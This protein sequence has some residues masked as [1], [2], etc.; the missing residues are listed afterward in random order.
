MAERFV[1]PGVYTQERDFSFYVSSV[2][3]PALG[4]IGETPRG[5]AFVP[6]LV[7]SMG[8]FRE[9]FG[10]YDTEKFVPYAANGWFKHA[11]QAV[12]VRVLG[13]D[14]VY[15]EGTDTVIYITATGTTDPSQ[16]YIVAALLWT[17]APTGLAV[18]TGGG[19]TDPFTIE[20]T[21]P[22]VSGD[23]RL[24]SPTA[25]DYIG[26]VFPASSDSLASNFMKL[27]DVTGG[28]E[29]DSGTWTIVSSHTQ[30]ITA[31][32]HPLAMNSYA[33]ARTPLIVSD[34]AA[35]GQAGVG[36]FT[37]Y[38]RADGVAANQQLKIAIEN[39][40]AASGDF[41]IVVREWDDLDNRQ[42]VLE[43][44]NKLSMTQSATTYIARA[45]GDSVDGETG[46][47]EPLSKY[48]WVEV[49][50]GDH[51]G[52]VP[53]G[54]RGVN[55][56]GDDG[57]LFRFPNFPMTLDYDPTISTSR[58]YLG[59][60][61]QA[62]SKD[63]VMFNE[64]SQWNL[65]ETDDAIV[66]SGF[67]IDS[68]ASSSAG[69]ITS[70]SGLTDWTKAEAKFLVPVL[71]GRDGWSRTM[72]PLDGLDP[73]WLTSNATVAEAF[74]DAIDE[75]SNPEEWNMN[76]LAMPG[77]AVNSTVGS[78]AIDMVESRADTL[79][80]GDMPKDL[81]SAAAAA[82]IADS[83]DTNYAATYWPYVQFFDTDNQQSVWY[84]PTPQALE[85]IAYT[86]SVAYPWWAAAGMNRGLLTD[87]VKAEYRLTQGER[88]ELYE[89]K[90]NP[91]ATF[92]GQGIVIWGQKTLQTRT[93][94]LDRINVRRML[95]YVRKVIAGASKFVLFEPN[96]QAT[97]DR[98]QAIIQPVLDLVRI[99]RGLEDF[100]IVIDESVNTPEVI[101]RGQIIAQIF[102]KPTKA[103]ETIVLY[104]NI[105][106]Q[107]VEFEE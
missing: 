97:R 73:T 45:I 57:D 25:A 29:F 59:V 24:G 38:T 42:V 105:T 69:Y 15:D 12:V 60:N 104:F 81:S 31:N 51:A 107:G 49:E 71:G 47:Y 68:G 8:E 32:D 77:I 11:D 98:L 55:A 90:I 23:V 41:D 56:P 70:V 61:W 84:P 64:W 20:A 3:T 72:G 13:K 1:S 48:I 19:L 63:Q 44:F 78:Y 100:R 4:L 14:D 36:L 50:A 30:T 80:I 53:A 18:E 39:I 66:L 94:A 34:I 83:I 79:Y 92:P 88:D 37:I 103:A 89:G 95:L 99:K 96:D 106:A 7:R 74:K 27:M 58:Q 35:P 93:T 85:A 6:S 5:P 46:E 76:V 26:R 16:E 9:I 62:L 82:T 52:R 75:L 10:D 65:D 2:G 54:F 17:G 102:I 22:N 40:D 43:R 67:H 28:H 86:D 91:I 87:V 101:D 21:S 33:P